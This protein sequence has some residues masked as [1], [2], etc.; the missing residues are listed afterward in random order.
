MWLIMW[1]CATPQPDW[2]GQCAAGVVENPRNSVRDLA[3]S[4]HCCFRSHVLEGSIL[5]VYMD[6]F[7]TKGWSSQL[8]SQEQDRVTYSTC[9]CLRAEHAWGVWLALPPHTGCTGAHGVVSPWPLSGHQFWQPQSFVNPLHVNRLLS[10]R[11]V[12]QYSNSKMFQITSK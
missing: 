4:P 8:A 11:K 9:V 5:C 12:T 7:V 10:T 2:A 6:I 3:R 1:L